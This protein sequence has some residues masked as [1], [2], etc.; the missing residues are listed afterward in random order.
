[1]GPERI[2]P[3]ERGTNQCTK[4]EE[5][6][7]VLTLGVQVLLALGS[8]AGGANLVRR[9]FLQLKVLEF[10]IRELSLEYSLHLGRH[11]GLSGNTSICSTPQS[12]YRSLAAPSNSKSVTHHSSGTRL[13]AATVATPVLT[14]SRLRLAATGTAADEGAGCRTHQAVQGVQPHNSDSDFTPQR[15]LQPKPPDHPR[16]P[17]GHTSNLAVTGLGGN[18][19][20]Q[21][22]V[23]D[24]T[25]APGGAQGPPLKGRQSPGV[26]SYSRVAARR[27]R[28]AAAAACSGT[29]VKSLVQQAVQR[30]EAAAAA[31]QPVPR[32][33]L[34]GNFARTS[35]GGHSGGPAALE[36]TPAKGPGQSQRSSSSDGSGSPATHR[37]PSLALSSRGGSGASTPVGAE[38]FS[39]PVPG[40]SNLSSKQPQLT[41]DASL[42]DEMITEW[43]E[44]T[45]QEFVF[46][47]L[48]SDEDDNDDDVAAESDDHSS[49][50]AEQGAP[51]S[52]RSSDSSSKSGGSSSRSGG[53]VSSTES[54]GFVGSRPVPRLFLVQQNG[55]QAA[56]A[57]AIS[58]AEASDDAGD[59][60]RPGLDLED[61]F[62]R[63]MEAEADGGFDGS[64]DDGSS[65][66]Y[67][68]AGSPYS[69]SPRS[70]CSNQDPGHPAAEVAAE[71]TESIANTEAAAAA[72]RGDV[73]HAA[74]E[75]DVPALRDEELDEQLLVSDTHR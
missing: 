1:M 48:S 13:N 62:E 16:A 54:A 32:L 26:A 69:G 20:Q 19:M 18:V 66:S 17:A 73:S 75:K 10:L 22:G 5:A 43:E 44:R 9:R 61:D 51:H 4:N 2:V 60:Y 67:I 72:D 55:T 64:S 28:P 34:N 39:S 23:S 45:G 8:H 7:L 71:P 12:S 36:G 59:S 27:Q 24:R 31:A 40:G 38:L 33:S 49:L 30:F 52:R 41:G 15:A 21:K 50:S 11:G 6:A 14:A 58:G 29:P 68:A 46:E 25:T 3:S 65:S 70:S 57:A 74:D 53:S 42:D 37:E 47:G 56:A 63:M 35:N